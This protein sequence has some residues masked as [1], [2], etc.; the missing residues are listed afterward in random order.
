MSVYE[1]GLRLRGKAVL[2]V[3]G[4]T[5]AGRRVP[6]LIDAGARVLV[7]APEVTTTLSDL[8]AAGELQWERR[9]WRTG[10]GDDAWFV[11]AATDDPAVNAAVAAEAESRRT[12]CVRSDDAEASD[13]WTLARAAFDGVSVAVSASGDP[14]RAAAVRDA[15]AAAL[16][17]GEID[18]PRTRRA[19]PAGVALVGAGPGDADLITLRGL[20]LLRQAEVVVS[21]RLAPQELLDMLG[22]DVEIVDAAKLPYGRHTTQ[23]QINAV[24]VERARE[25]K[26]V[27]RLKGGDGFVFGRGA[28]ELDACLDAGVPVEVVPGL[29]SSIAGPA[30]AGIPVTERGVVHDFTVATGHVPPGPQSLVDWHALGAGNG[31]VVLLMAVKNRAAIAAALMAGGR[32]GSTPVRIVESATTKNQTVRECELSDLGVTEAHHPAVIVIG[33]V[34]ARGRGL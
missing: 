18:A 17:S 34:A 1:V 26:F 22:D 5:I 21:D 31:T 3:G 16:R 29:S 8:A 32:P 33:A 13:A 6:R 20:E 9:E 12:W 24:M 15:V 7:V 14:R 27:V 4:G 23:E 28:E 19:R 30:A 25:G 10:D 11:L 2:V